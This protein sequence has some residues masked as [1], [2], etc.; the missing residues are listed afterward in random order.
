[1]LIQVG[2]AMHTNFLENNNFFLPNLITVL[3]SE[4]TRTNPEPLAH[5]GATPKVSVFY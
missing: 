4:Y 2:G 3:R 1:M 5:P